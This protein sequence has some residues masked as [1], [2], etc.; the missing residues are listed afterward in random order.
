MTPERKHY[1][2]WVEEQFKFLAFL[3]AQ[4]CL[5]NTRQGHDKK[6]QVGNWGRKTKLTQ[7]ASVNAPRHCSEMFLYFLRLLAARQAVDFSQVG[8]VFITCDKQEKDLL[9]PT[10]VLLL[11]DK[12]VSHP[13]VLKLRER[14]CRSWPMSSL[15]FFARQALARV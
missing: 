13:S 5:A 3:G 1:L 6:N 8:Q 14:F 2:R 9:P 11:A 15:N 10:G 12:Q 4:T 7:G